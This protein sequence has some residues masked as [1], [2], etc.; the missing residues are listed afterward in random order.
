MKFVGKTVKDPYFRKV[1]LEI[2]GRVVSE[3][4]VIGRALTYKQARALED[5]YK[6][7][8]YKVEKENA[9]KWGRVYS[10]YIFE[11]TKLLSN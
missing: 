11:I 8:G 10:V 3:F 6:L 7:L 2:R 1:G 4:K 9:F 5:E